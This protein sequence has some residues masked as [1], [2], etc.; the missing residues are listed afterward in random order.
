MGVKNK[1]K[2]QKKKKQFIVLKIESNNRKI[3]L[4]AYTKAK[5]SHR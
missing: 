1:N 4:S 3:L 5:N 2:K